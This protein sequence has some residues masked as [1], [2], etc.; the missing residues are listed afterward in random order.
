MVDDS[1]ATLSRQMVWQIIY[2]FH[3]H[4]SFTISNL[5]GKTN[6]VSNNFIFYFFVHAVIQVDIKRLEN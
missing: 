4:W 6:L 2:S 1:L 3:L 5:L